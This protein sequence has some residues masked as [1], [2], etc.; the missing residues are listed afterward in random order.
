MKYHDAIWEFASYLDFFSPRLILTK[1]CRSVLLFFYRLFCCFIRFDH[2]KPRSHVHTRIKNHLVP[3][4]LIKLNGKE[5]R[6]HPL[7]KVFVYSRLIV[8]AVFSLLCL[9]FYISFFYF[10][11]SQTRLSQLKLYFFFHYFGA[12]LFFIHS[13]I[14]IFSSMCE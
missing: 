8:S 12:L 7:N 2:T 1:P 4:S 14:E 6:K 3:I 11:W 5:A 13:F 9:V 10:F